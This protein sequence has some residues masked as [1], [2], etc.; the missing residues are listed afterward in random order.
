MAS[1]AWDG[2]AWDGASLRQSH[3]SAVRLT[4]SSTCTHLDAVY[5]G[6]RAGQ[7][8][9]CVSIHEFL[10]ARSGGSSA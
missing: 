1:A 10:G 8:P 5:I 2:L 4:L 6:W 9:A 3:T 7:L